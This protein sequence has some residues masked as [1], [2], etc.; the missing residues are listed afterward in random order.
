[1][2]KDHMIVM[3]YANYGNLLS[4]LEQ[5]TNKLTWKMKLGCLKDIAF[6]LQIIHESNLIHC[7]LHGGNIILS[8]AENRDLL[9]KPFICDLGLSRSVHLLTS[10]VPTVQG[11]LPYIAPEVLHTHRFTQASDIYAFG[12][13]MYLIATGE[14]PYREYSFDKCL[15]MRVCEG[16][17]PVMPDSAPEAYRKLAEKCCNA[18]P[19][20]RPTAPKL[21][22]EIWKLLRVDDH[23]W[24]TVYYNK[25][26]RPLSRIEKESKYSSKILP[27]GNLPRPR[28]SWALS[29]AAGTNK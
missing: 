21:F 19:N 4:Y 3:Q 25:N 18:D 29:S 8:K 24:N 5:N 13:I 23:L 9:T 16:L 6:R 15:A 26:I 1:M 2:T 7:D 28:N 14:P 12:I 17:R 11:V 20:E 10:D 22:D 27:T